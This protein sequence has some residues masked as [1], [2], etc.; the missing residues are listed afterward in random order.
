MR[1]EYRTI[2][3]MNSENKNRPVQDVL[4]EMGLVGWKLK[5]VYRGDFIFER[6]VRDEK[7]K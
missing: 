4:N 5:A 6:E 1:Y 2:Y 7:A 3:M